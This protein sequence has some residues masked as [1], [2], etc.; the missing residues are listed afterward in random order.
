[1]IKKLTLLVGIGAGYVLGAKAGKERYQ[2]IKNMAVDLRGRPEVQQATQTLQSTASDLTSKAKEAVNQQVDKA[3]HT[4][5]DLTEP[6]DSSV[7][8]G[9]GPSHF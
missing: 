5:V 4:S 2:Q 6:A 8:P 9:P 3:G 7:A 1:V